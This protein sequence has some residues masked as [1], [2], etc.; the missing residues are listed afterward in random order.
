MGVTLHLT[1][2]SPR[3]I[4]SVPFLETSAREGEKHWVDLDEQTKHDFP[5]LA[6][7]V[8]WLVEEIIPRL[9]TFYT[10][11]FG[12]TITAREVELLVYRPLS[13]LVRQ[14]LGS[15]Y[16]LQKF[17]ATQAEVIALD[18]RDF[19][20]PN[21]DNQLTD[22]LKNSDFFSLQIFTIILE[23]RGLTVRR[24]RRDGFIDA[25]NHTAKKISKDERRSQW[26]YTYAAW[27]AR[28]SGA[29][30][31][32]SSQPVQVLKGGLHGNVA[33]V[34]SGRM[35]VPL[36]SGL[37]LFKADRALRQ[38]LKQSLQRDGDNALLQSFIGVLSKCLPRTYAEGM[39]YYTRVARRELTR[40]KQKYTL[41]AFVLADR[42]F[43]PHE[44]FFLRELM[45]EGV[46]VCI[47]QHGS[48]YGESKMAI[49]EQ[50]EARVADIFLTWGWR[51]VSNQVPYHAV[52]LATLEKRPAG[53]QFQDLLWL[54]R[55]SI[56]NSGWEYLLF[57]DYDRTQ[58]QFYLRL[59]EPL[60]QRIVLRLLT[61]RFTKKDNVSVW[62]N[63]YPGIRVDYMEGKLVDKLKTARMVVIDYFFSTAF[64]E[65]ILT[66]TPVIVFEDNKTPA[67]SDI[68]RPVYDRLAAVGVVHFSYLSAAD[69][70]NANI[71]TIDAWWSS[72]PVQEAVNE[73][74][75]LFSREQAEAGSIDMYF[76]TNAVRT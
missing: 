53:S 55:G 31:K 2:S 4:S 66:N 67:F 59:Q 9:T 33:H 76:E 34:T 5:T 73:Y 48:V 20:I 28:F 64:P 65:C 39:P 46:K 25:S 50:S 47:V 63:R 23:I 26:L 18:E 54:T 51:K 72:A 15:Y 37:F 68:A 56:G 71:D 19:F 58:E 61:T 32:P 75:F 24:L 44:R 35:A 38:E 52:K 27:K 30:E 62:R 57:F 16:F 45:R 29:A 12:L 69:F 49:W 8:D 43:Y 74:K 11:K 1:K 42:F 22:A 3:N 41:P 21:S 14:F 13:F 70:I 10:N 36:F 60:R 17:D 6:E 40:Y 7:Q